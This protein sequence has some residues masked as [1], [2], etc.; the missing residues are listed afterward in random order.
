MLDKFQEEVDNASHRNLIMKET[1]MSITQVEVN[2]SVI[3]N[4]LD[5]AVNTIV[6][7]IFT[8]KSGKVR[9]MSARKGVTKGLKGGG[10]TYGTEAKSQYIQI[11]DMA[12][13]EYRAVNRDTI[14][15]IRV[16]GNVYTF[17]I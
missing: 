6:G 3:N 5:Q 13:R 8:E 7:I 1:K 11:F 12:K 16:R 14:K 17:N 2:R 10:S 15:V 4:I 9:K